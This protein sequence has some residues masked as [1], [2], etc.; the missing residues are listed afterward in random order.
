M[1][2]DIVDGQNAETAQSVPLTGAKVLR[3]PMKNNSVWARIF[4]R[5]DLYLMM[6]PG[7]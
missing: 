7:L 4:K 3:R 2:K 1:K 6:V 5:W